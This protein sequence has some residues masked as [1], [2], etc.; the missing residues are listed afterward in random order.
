M[1][2]VNGEPKKFTE[3]ISLYDFLNENNYD[4]T[5]VAVIINEDIVSRNL[6]KEKIIKDNDEIE[7]VTFVGGGWFLYY[8]M[9]I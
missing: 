8:K 3:N 5:R 9:E 4:A 1:I 6:Y 7:V 2:K